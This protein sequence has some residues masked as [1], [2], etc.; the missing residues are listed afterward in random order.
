MAIPLIYLEGNPYQRGT[1][2]GEMARDQIR[3]VLE[4]YKLLF[5][6]EAKLSWEQA[7][8]R[9]LLFNSAV[10]D[11]CPDIAEEIDGIA[12]GSGLE[13]ADILTL[14][15]RS[16]LLYSNDNCACTTIGIPPEASGNDKTYLAQNWNWCSLAKGTNV[17][18][19]IDQKPLPK[20]LLLT[21]AGLIGGRGLN[22]TGV[23]ST[24]NALPIKKGSLG[25]PVAFLQRM[26]LSHTNVPYALENICA[27]P[28]ASGSCMAFASAEGTLLMAEN[29][30][31]NFDVLLSD[32]YV[33]CHTNHWV[34]PLLKS[35][36]NAERMPHKA[37]YARLDWARRLT[38]ERFGSL[39]KKSIFETLSHHAS[40]VDSICQHDDPDLPV[41]LSHSTIWSMVINATDR[42]MWVTDGLPCSTKPVAYRFTE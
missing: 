41:Y 39:G 2:Y 11:H 33:M 3:L 4:E 24:H 19:E 25:L 14:N 9:A 23:A 40:F 29:L 42:V 6:K 30:P 21:E 38:H 17:V 10:M 35:D 5:E 32:G 18:L 16:D 8:E 34:S 36:P 26:A 1:N 7:K 22:D 15:C 27:L 13:Y 20:L 28:K 37:T 31:R 12:R